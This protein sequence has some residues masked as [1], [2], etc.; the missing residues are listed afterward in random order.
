MPPSWSVVATVDEPAALVVAFALHHLECGASEV[1]LFLDGPNPQAEDAL[2]SIAQVKLVVCDEAHWL[3]CVRR[4]KPKLHTGRQLVNADIAYQS[5]RA[6][7][8]LHCDCDEFVSDGHALA[9][10]L[11]VLEPKHVYLRLHMAERAYVGPETE[12]IFEGVFRYPMK[13]FATQGPPV[14]GDL[15]PFL[16]DGLTGHRAGKAVVR[17]GLPIKMG[18]HSPDGPPPHR[19]AVTRL[20][21]FDGLTRLHY[22]I[23]LLRR[24]HE[25]P[26]S[27]LRHGAPRIVQFERLRAM[28]GQPDRAH[29]LVADLKSL[30]PEQ[31]A[32]LRALQALDERNFSA[33]GENPLAADLSTTSINAALRARYHDFLQAYAP[34]FLRA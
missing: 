21:H 1:N 3:D 26:I 4:R 7:W 24:A 16:K 32:K 19:D 20:L 25:P 31:I 17:T 6:D 15:V 33:L 18:I 30:N 9:L 27:P 28:A 12:N 34:K 5:C 11:G 22:L 8:L 2:R 14:Y 23:K 10:E 29:A 13:D